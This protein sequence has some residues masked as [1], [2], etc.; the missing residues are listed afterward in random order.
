MNTP[1]HQRLMHER[2]VS[3]SPLSAQAGQ[4]HVDGNTGTCN[5]NH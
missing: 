1:Q 5:T 3:E 2:T 4:L